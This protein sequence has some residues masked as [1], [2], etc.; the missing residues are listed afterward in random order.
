MTSNP[1]SSENKVAYPAYREWA[2]DYFENHQLQR[3]GQSFMNKFGLDRNDPELFYETD[4]KKADV[5]ILDKY[6]ELPNN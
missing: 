5:L 1:N 3:Y 4:P 2:I 6:V